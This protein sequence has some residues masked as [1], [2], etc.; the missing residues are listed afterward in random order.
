M[1][2]RQILLTCFNEGPK[3]EESEITGTESKLFFLH[4]PK[5]EFAN[6]TGTK[7]GINSY[8]YIIIL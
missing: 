4:G 6:I 2:R 8:A 3:V 5:L 1:S 7:R